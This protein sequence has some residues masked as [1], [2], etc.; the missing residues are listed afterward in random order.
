MCQGPM[1]HVHKLNLKRHVLQLLQEQSSRRGQV[2]CRRRCPDDLGYK[3]MEYL[4]AL[5]HA[6]C[7]CTGP[8]LTW[9]LPVR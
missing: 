7:L 6:V 5:R 4:S 3:W 9:N 2:R 1:L 8:A